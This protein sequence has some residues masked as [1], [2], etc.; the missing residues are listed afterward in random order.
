MFALSLRVFTTILQG[1][2]VTLQVSRNTIAGNMERR[3]GSVRNAQKDMLFNLIGKPI[4]RL[5]VLENTDV[6]VA[7][8]SQGNYLIL[9][10]LLI[11]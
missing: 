1:L 9:S 5:A 4:L 11:I 10:P 7:L 2:W 8:F 6:T 3:N